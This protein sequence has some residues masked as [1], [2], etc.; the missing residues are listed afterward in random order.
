MGGCFLCSLFLCWGRALE[1]LFILFAIFI[2]NYLFIFTVFFLFGGA[3]VVPRNGVCKA[4]SK[5]RKE[6]IHS[7]RASGSD[8]KRGA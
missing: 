2:I 3:G 6:R 1:V 4:R 7:E 8:S 5:L